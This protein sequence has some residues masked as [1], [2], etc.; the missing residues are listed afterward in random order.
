MIAKYINGTI[1]AF[2]EKRCRSYLTATAL[3]KLLDFLAV[4]ERNQL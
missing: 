1:S 2:N 3:K 4:Y